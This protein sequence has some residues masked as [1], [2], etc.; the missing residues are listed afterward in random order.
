MLAAEKRHHFW[1][2]SN[3][4]TALLMMS[5]FYQKYFFQIKTSLNS[6]SDLNI[7]INFKECW[8][9]TFFKGTFLSEDNDAFI[10]IPNIRTF[11]FPETENLNF[12]N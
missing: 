6:N 9:C 11:F 12:G 7:I 2:S 10:K 1:C 4:F 8:L 3:K 5:G